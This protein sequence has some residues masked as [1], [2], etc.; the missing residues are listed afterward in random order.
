MGL[1][2]PHVEAEEPRLGP[3]AQ[4]GQQEDPVSLVPDPREGGEVRGA[5][6][7][8]QEDEQGEEERGSQVGG[9]Q[10]DPPRPAS[11]L[12][13]VS[14]EHQEERRQGHD[15][16]GHQE[17]HPVPGQED[18]EHP[19]RQEG[20]EGPVDVPGEEGGVPQIG[21]P[22]DRRQEG[23]PQHRHGEPS[24]QEVQPQVEGSRKPPRGGPGPPE[25][26]PPGRR[27]WGSVPAPP[28]RRTPQTGREE[29]L[30]RS[31]GRRA[32]R[33]EAR[34]APREARIRVLMGRP[35]FGEDRLV[36]R[37]A[38][39][40]G[41]RGVRSGRGRTRR[42]GRDETKNPTLRWGGHLD[43]GRKTGS[44]PLGTPGI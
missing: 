13:G 28:Q 3:E 40:T 7:G 33:E 6:Q 1:R 10:V 17:D 31:P 30:F 38:S 2:Q 4:Q 43:P 24:G 34:K 27:P 8:P 9:R 44:R 19:P 35:R 21:P 5:P 42:G 20:E 16:P 18:E 32:P 22:V 41:M 36:R 15:L 29:G 11:P 39:G 23:D 14:G 37:S 26:L 25:G 12:V